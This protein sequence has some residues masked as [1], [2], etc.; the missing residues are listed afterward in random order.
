MPESD[1]FE[2]NEGWAACTRSG[3]DLFQSLSPAALKS[4]ATLSRAG[5][6]PAAA[7]L[8]VEG[9]PPRGVHLLRAGRIKLAMTSAEGKV[10]ILRVAGP[11]ELLGLSPA[12]SGCAHEFT[13]E[14]LEV[15]RVSFIR[16][17]DFRRLIQEEP[18]FSF[19]VIEQLSRDYSAAC[20]QVRTLGLTRKATKKV[21]RFLLDWA[22]RGRDSSP[23]LSVSLPLTHEEIAQA[24][25]LTRE[26][27][28]R[29]L[30]EFK[31]KKLITMA[32]PDVIICN[33]PALHSLSAA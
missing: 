25:G 13:A 32:G 33:R 14:T 21:A 22:A 28:T 4:F 27:V 31:H 24:V 16:S 3:A 30:A 1:G 15:C 5:L 8:F 18:G 19:L 2:S 26:T 12:V 20:S 7:I 17:G 9:Q 6:Y 11:G 23:E 10:I 29:T